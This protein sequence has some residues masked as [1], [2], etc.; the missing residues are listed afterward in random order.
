MVSAGV[1]RKN[2]IMIINPTKRAMTETSNGDS[3]SKMKSSKILSNTAKYK[4]R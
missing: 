4:I 1:P 3:S 2:N